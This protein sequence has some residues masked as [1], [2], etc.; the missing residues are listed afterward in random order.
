[1]HVGTVAVERTG[2]MNLRSG[3]VLAL[4]VV[5]CSLGA[6]VSPAPER[7]TERPTAGEEE[8]E[9]EARVTAAAPREARVRRSAIVPRRVARVADVPRELPAAGRYRVHM[10]DVGTGLAILVQ[11]ADFTLLYDGGTNDRAEQGSLQD[12]NDETRLLSY[13]FAA[14]GPSGG[15]SCA[16]AGDPWPPA[17]GSVRIDHVVLSHPHADHGNMLDSVLACYDVGTVWDAGHVNRTLFLRAF[18]SAVVAEAG[19]RFRTVRPIPANRTYDFGQG[20]RVQF[21]QALAW[22]T[23]ATGHVEELGQGARFTVVHAD[24]RRAVGDPNECSIVLRVELG[25]RSVLLT[26]DV[27]SGPRADPSEPAVGAEREMID[28]HAEL[29]DVDVLQ[30]AHHGSMTSSR[31]EFLAAVSPSI[32]LVSSGPNEYSGV[33]LPDPEVMR[34]LERTGARV[35]STFEHDAQCADDSGAVHDRIGRE[36]GPGGCDNWV[37]DF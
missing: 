5:G 1:M 8:P 24:P 13:L 30:V 12:Q 34:A 26:G 3:R 22:E 15:P 17:D 10:I 6:C 7:V 29:L 27:E 9:R 25:G 23:F 35:L 14:L 36:T 32:A 28:H 19:V 4:L 37:L 16:P 21:P 2:A 31:A 33:R 20:N 11:G 18:Y